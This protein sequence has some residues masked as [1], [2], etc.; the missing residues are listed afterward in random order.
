MYGEAGVGIT[1][2]NE[3]QGKI[4][5]LLPIITI[6]WREIIRF[7]RQRSQLFS[8]IAQPLVFWLLI[9]SGLSASFRPA[10]TSD[11]TGYI[12]YFYPGIVVLRPFS[13]QFLS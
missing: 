7:Y 13:L 10:G 6:W 11:E 8:A 12:A 4:K 9:G 5:S 3:P 2:L 1:Y